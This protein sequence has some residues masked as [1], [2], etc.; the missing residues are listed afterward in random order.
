ML[1]LCRYV[2]SASRLG[3]VEA[4]D[5]YT[6]ALAE[7]RLPATLSYSDCIPMFHHCETSS[8]GYNTFTEACH[9]SHKARSAQKA[10]VMSNTDSASWLA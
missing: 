8:L 1:F 10:L 5:W 6:T 3:G 7:L 2:C 4:N 9:A